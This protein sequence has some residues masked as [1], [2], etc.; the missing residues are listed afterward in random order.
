MKTGRFLIAALAALLCA[1]PAGAQQIVRS[2]NGDRCSGTVTTGGVSQIASNGD[3]ARTWLVVQNPPS[4]TEALYVDFGPNHLASTTLSTE[5]APG[6]SISFVAGVVPSGQI[7]V[8]AATTGHRFIC[9][10]GR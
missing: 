2:M 5:L 9:F 7:N 8:T 6:G 1:S 4:A 3:G 10:A